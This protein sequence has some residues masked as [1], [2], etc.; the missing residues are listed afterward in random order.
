MVVR[1]GE[2][3]RGEGG[4]V[5]GGEGGCGARAGGGQE[6]G[7]GGGCRGDELGAGAARSLQEKQHIAKQLD[8]NKPQPGLHKHR[9]LHGS[10]QNIDKV[11][12]LGIVTFLL[13][14]RR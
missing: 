10:A 12:R 13:K 7:S 6:G 3:S 4:G 8:H 14:K 2:G 9:P 11:G 1:T 5:V